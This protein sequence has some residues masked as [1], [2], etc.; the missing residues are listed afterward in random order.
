MDMTEKNDII[1]IGS[2]VRLL[3]RSNT[4]GIVASGPKKMGQWVAT[5]EV[6][7][8]EEVKRLRADDL[9][10]VRFPYE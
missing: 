4:T 3:G 7:A 1:T 5:Y 8:G 2:I 10:V 6:L 9:S